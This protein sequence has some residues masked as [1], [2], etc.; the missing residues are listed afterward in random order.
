MNPIGSVTMIYHYSIL[1]IVTFG[2]NLTNFSIHHQWYTHRIM[3][4]NHQCVYHRSHSMIIIKLINRLKSIQMYE[5]ML[6]EKSEP[7]SPRNNWKG[8][9]IILIHKI[10]WHDCDV[11]RLLYNLTF[12]NGRWRC[13]SKI[14]GNTFVFLSIFLYLQFFFCLLIVTF[15]SLHRMKERRFNSEEGDDCKPI[16]WLIEKWLINII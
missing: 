16:Y 12:P 6:Y 3:F 15:D 11:M 8:W 14:E 1:I 7:H 13:G 10:I 4:K 5:T 9:K 2:Q